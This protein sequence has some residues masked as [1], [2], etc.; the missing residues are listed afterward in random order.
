MVEEIHGLLKQ[1][2]KLQ[3]PRKL[4]IKYCN[5]VTY[6]NISVVRAVL[7]LVLSSLIITGCSTQ[8][9]I[10][11][12]LPNYTIEQQGRAQRPTVLLFQDP[13]CGLNDS[14]SK[15]LNKTGYNVLRIT[16]QTESL[17]V[18]NSDHKERRG[19]EGVE[20]YN[21]LAQKYNIKALASTGLEIHGSIPWFVNT[22]VQTLFFYNYY[23]GSL[24]DHI[25]SSMGKNVDVFPMYIEEYSAVELFEL[26][27]KYPPPSGKISSYPIRYVHSIWQEDP[28][29]YLGMNER[30]VI[31]FRIY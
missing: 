31:F 22:P 12:N 18:Q 19:Y 7:F 26:L 10:I 14:I 30:E 28:K 5:T 15:Y 27:S 29:S 23:P 2:V 25:L 9:T 17:E 3:E 11:T 20:L 16:K 8:Q 21:E 6:V 4:K 24:Q 13:G 1:Q